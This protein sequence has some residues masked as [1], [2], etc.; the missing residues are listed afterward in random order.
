MKKTVYLFYAFAI[1]F[2]ASCGAAVIVPVAQILTA[3]MILGKDDSN[4]SAKKPSGTSATA[5]KMEKAYLHLSGATLV[6]PLRDIHLSGA[7]T[8]PHISGTALSQRAA[9][10]HLSGNDTGLHLSGAYSRPFR[11]KAHLSG[12][13]HELHFSGASLFQSINP[14]IHISGKTIS[15]E[16]IVS[17]PP[18]IKQSTEKTI[19]TSLHLSGSIMTQATR[20][21]HISGADTGFHISGFPFK[22][23]APK[24]HISGNGLDLHL[25]GASSREPLQEIHFSGNEIELHLSGA[26]LF[27]NITPPIH[28]SGKAVIF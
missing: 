13:D 3:P 11:K 9:K 19:T 28:L 22:P 21:L 6:K 23:P 12:N 18:A 27:Q 20:N 2:I 14:A 1:L 4:H 15:S 17:I 10:I 5:E 26:A 8:V 7:D 25:S 24:I 16:S